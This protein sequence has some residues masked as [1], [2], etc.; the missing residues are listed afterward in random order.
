MAGWLASWGDP[1]VLQW[2]LPLVNLAAVLAATYLLA[3]FLRS[4][5]RPTWA[6]LAFPTS[7]GVLVGVSQRRLGS[8][9]RPRCS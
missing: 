4:R 3:V 5:D 7:I 6:A 8:A 1:D 9:R 2:T